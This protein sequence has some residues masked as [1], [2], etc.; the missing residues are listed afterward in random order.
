MENK[1]EK[2]Y[3]LITAICMVVGIVVG[4]GVFFKAQDILNITQGNM[5]LGILAWII[6]GII[7]LVCSINFS[8]FATHFEKVNGVV[9][10][11]EDIVGKRFAYYVGWFMTTIYY[12]TLTSVLAWLTARYTLVFVTTAFPSI[13]L[14]VPADQGGCVF[15]PECMAL[16]LFFLCFAYSINTLAPRLAG[17]FQVGT[18][19]IKMVPLLLMMVVGTLVGL[20]GESGA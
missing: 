1:L 2:K 18:T 8:T 15:G 7:M 19:F 3:G 14:T 20:F 17:H 11:A 16:S 9:D 5:P 4:S 12:P 6:G 13:T 10:Y